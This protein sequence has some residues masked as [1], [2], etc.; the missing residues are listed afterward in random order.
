MRV[1]FL[2]LGCTTTSTTPL[3]YTNNTSVK[4]Q[5]L[6]EVTYESNDRIGYLEL[7]RAARAKYPNCDYVIDIM[8]DRK[9]EV[10][11][12]FI[13]KMKE[14][15][16]YTMR[17]IAI[18]YLENVGDSRAG[19]GSAGT[20][21]SASTPAS[22]SS[23]SSSSSSVQRQVPVDVIF[24]AAGWVAQHDNKSNSSVSIGIEQIDGRERNV[25]TIYSRLADVIKRQAG[26][27]FNNTEIFQKF[28]NANGIRFKVLGD[29]IEWRLSFSTSNIKDSAYYGMILK[30]QIKEVTS[31]DI[32]F[33]KLIQPKWGKRAEFSTSNITGMSIER[34]GDTGVT[35]SS[36]IKIFDFEIY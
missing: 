29:G 24:E 1:F 10:T 35:G 16:T 2:V 9:T 7:L 23:A 11:T 17:G 5:I 8:I 34:N 3:V 18:K 6:G 36:T 15:V 4:F 13:L 28:R 30:T 14:E 32:P 21:T 31:F 22:A 19:T 20:A 25:L 12:F 33:S 27:N 26:A